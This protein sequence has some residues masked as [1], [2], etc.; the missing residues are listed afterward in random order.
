[1][2]YLKFTCQLALGILFYC[3]APAL[4]AQKMTIIKGAVVDADTKEPL[5][6]VNIAFTGTTVGTTSDLDGTYVLESKFAANTMQVSYV[7]YETQTIPIQLNMRQEVN[8]ALAPIS[9]K[10]ADV[11]IKAKKGGYKRKDN[12]AV[13]LM[14]NVIDHK[15]DNRMEALDFYHLDK[16]EKIE[17]DINNFDPEKFK[18]R[19]ALKKFEFLFDYV[20]TSE[21]NGKPYLPFFIQETA[22]KIYYRKDPQAKKE[23][24]EGVKVTGIEEYVDLKDF[25]TMLDVLYQNVNIYEDNVRILDLAFMSPLNPIANTYYRFYITDT[26]A[27]VNDVPCTR[28]S[29]MPVNNQNIA[30][31]GDLFIKR[32]SSYAVVKAD[33][34]ITRQINL[35]FIQDL[36]LVQEF[37]ER[38][39]VWV[40]SKDQLVIDFAPFKKGTGVF[41]TRQVDYTNHVFNQKQNDSKYEGTQNVVS[42]TDAYKKDETFW[43]T[44]RQDT[45]T[46]K[47]QGI[48]QMID[49]LQKV[50]T[51]RTVVNVL[52]IFGTGYKAFG[53]VDVGPVGAFY[54][55]N[56]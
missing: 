24:R 26:T 56:P 9:I 8:V 41:G 31:K 27:V 10:L 11:E 3:L 18:K 16:Y 53:P 43:E 21:L 51:F 6:F 25:T 14:K 28:V 42:S 15:D 29:F 44:A 30:F 13:A 37:T 48:Y 54:S 38:E 35:N 34:G 33:F 23:Y 17:F 55:F 49:T 19:K 12:P 20:D 22:A 2:R 32:D 7:G 40:L 36:K 5:P 4:F 47:E 45:L 46:E 1:M 52:S 39:G 50:P